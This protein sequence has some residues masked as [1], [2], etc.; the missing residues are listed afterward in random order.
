MNTLAC[1]D[2]NFSNYTGLCLTSAK[3]ILSGSHQCQHPTWWWALVFEI[4]RRRRHWISI[5]FDPIWPFPRGY[6]CVLNWPPR[7]LAQMFGMGE[8]LCTLHPCHRLWFYAAFKL[9]LL[10]LL[11]MLLRWIRKVC[12]GTCGF[13][14]F[15]WLE[16]WHL[17]PEIR[18]DVRI[19]GGGC[20]GK[21]GV[22]REVARIL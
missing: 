6:G 16:G 7:K 3:F 20:H 19:R 5:I 22:T 21:P 2:E 13:T 8:V 15:L 9:L 10:L 4:M 18:Y 14:P 12:P 11:L 1:D 17:P